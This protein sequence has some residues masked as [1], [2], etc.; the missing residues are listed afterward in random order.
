MRKKLAL[1]GVVVVLVAFAASTLVSAQTRSGMARG[2]AR[3]V[4][5]AEADVAQ[6]T[7]T[8][9]RLLQNR[10]EWTRRLARA[11]SALDRAPAPPAN[12]TNT[13]IDEPDPAG[14]DDEDRPEEDDPEEDAPP[15]TETSEDAP[16]SVQAG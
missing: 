15:M 4:K 2:G 1:F 12:G 16:G 7:L 10:L 6:G 3:T 13:I 5:A 14:Y 8:I 11:L 9:Q